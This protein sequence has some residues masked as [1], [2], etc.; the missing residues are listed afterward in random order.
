MSRVTARIHG[1]SLKPAG[2]ASSVF[3]SRSP[4]AGYTPRPQRSPSC[5]RSRR[6]TSSLTPMTSRSIP[7]VP[8]V[9]AV[10]MSIKPRARSALPIS[11]PE[12]SSSVRMSAASIRTRIAPCRS[13][14]QSSM[15]QSRRGSMRQS[16]ASDGV[17][18]G[19]VTAASA[20]APIISRRTA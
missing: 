3:R 10:S 9:P 13:S 4:V 16:R 14:A 5:P 6:S 2:I 12:P 20:S 18:S 11:L 8:P 17:R 1:S 19:Q 7:T 15:K